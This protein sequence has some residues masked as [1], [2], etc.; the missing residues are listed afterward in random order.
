MY[1][2]SEVN[3]SDVV[4][5]KPAKVVQQMVVSSGSFGFSNWS[6]SERQRAVDEVNVF[7]ESTKGKSVMVFTDGSVCDG[8]VGCG[9]CAAVLVPISGQEDKF[10]D[11][12]LAVGQKVTSVTCE[13]EGIALGLEL[14]VN[15]FRFARTDSKV[16]LCIIS[17]VTVLWR[18]IL[19]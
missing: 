1:L 8:S 2:S 3:V 7:I 12:N 4:M 11:C 19:S 14:S 15:Y 17:S 5:I 6:Q 16:N 9:A 18:L 13:L 10:H